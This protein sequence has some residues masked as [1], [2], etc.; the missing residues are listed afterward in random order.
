MSSWHG[1]IP[2]LMPSLSSFT[3]PVHEKLKKSMELTW[4]ES[5]QDACDTV[6]CLV[7]TYTA[8][9]YFDINRPITIQVDVPW[10]GLGTTLFQGVQISHHCLNSSYDQRPVL[11][12]HID[13]CYAN[14][15]YEMLASVFV[16]GHFHMFL[17]MHSLSRLAKTPGADQAEDAGRYTSLPQENAALLA[18]L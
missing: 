12:Q 7:C 8:L 15:E 10:K 11:Y 18:E 14:I 17:A 9:W 3:A 1:H 2:L 6:K 16:V 5:Y 4:N 13:Q